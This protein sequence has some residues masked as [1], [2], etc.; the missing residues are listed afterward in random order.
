MPVPVQDGPKSF[1][2]P[3]NGTL[4]VINSDPRVY[5]AATNWTNRLLAAIKLAIAEAVYLC[6][7]FLTQPADL[8]F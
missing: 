5:R 6:I 4:V 1:P 7:Q 2:Q 8:A 3:S